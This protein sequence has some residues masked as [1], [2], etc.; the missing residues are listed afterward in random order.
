LVRVAGAAL[1]KSLDIS[2]TLFLSG[3]EA[4]TPGKLDVFE[5]VGARVT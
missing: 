1:N 5:A 2:G 3:G 4:L